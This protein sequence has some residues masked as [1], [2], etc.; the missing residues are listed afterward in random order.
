MPSLQSF[1]MST[2]VGVAGMCVGGWLGVGGWVRWRQLGMG[3]ESTPIT[4]TFATRVIY[5]SSGAV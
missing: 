1:L 5:Q 2:Q 3:V 4:S